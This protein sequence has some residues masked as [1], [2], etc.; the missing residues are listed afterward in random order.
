MLDLN[1]PSDRELEAKI[2]SMIKKYHHIGNDSGKQLATFFTDIYNHFF[3][4]QEENDINEEENVNMEITE[5]FENI[6]SDQVQIGNVVTKTLSQQ[7][8]PDEKEPGNSAQLTTGTSQ[9]GYVKPL[10]YAPDQLNPLLNQTIKRIISVDSQYRDDKTCM[11]TNFSFNLSTPL[12]DVVSLKLYS[13]QIPYTWYTISKS[14]GSNFFYLK[15]NKPGIINN[16]SQDVFFD[17]S[18]GNYNAQELV[19]AVND[20]IFGNVTKN[21]VGKTDIYSDVSFGKTNVTYDSN[22]SLANLNI[23]IKKQFNENSYYLQFENLTS[24]NRDD[25]GLIAYLPF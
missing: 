12:K 5:N 10:D 11:S 25:L 17:I 3:D 21:K 8:N 13:V 24:P 2:I 20:S 14:F 7:I 6:N 18:A 9:I 23:D 4:N 22:T 15:G 1:N 16:P 19:S